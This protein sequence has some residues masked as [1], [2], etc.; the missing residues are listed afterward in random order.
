MKYREHELLDYQR[1]CGSMVNGYDI[2]G[3]QKWAK[4]NV[5]ASMRKKGNIVAV[6]RK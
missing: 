4:K 1:S 5:A 3:E 2:T 6:V